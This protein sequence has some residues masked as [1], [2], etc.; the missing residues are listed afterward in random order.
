VKGQAQKQ[1]DSHKTSRADQLRA[2]L[3]G[4]QF[5]WRHRD[6]QRGLGSHDQAARLPTSHGKTGVLSLRP[7][8]RPSQGSSTLTATTVPGPISWV[9]DTPFGTLKDE[10][11][12]DNDNGD[13]DDS[14]NDD[15]NDNNDKT[16]HI[17][18]NTDW[19]NQTLLSVSPVI[20]HTSIS[21]LQNQLDPFFQ[22][23][24]STSIHDRN[25]MHYCTAGYLR[26]RAMT[27][28]S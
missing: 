19:R 13:D 7:S 18:N 28:S 23:A 27:N 25:L 26:S 12:H 6:Y 5:T 2:S 10:G 24:G 3:A 14:D 8:R 15:D 17:T 21:R 4:S 1:Q 16:Q 9:L 11:D 22:L 20:S